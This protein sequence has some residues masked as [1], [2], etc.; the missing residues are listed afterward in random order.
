MFLESVFDKLGGKVPN[1]ILSDCYM[2]AF[3]AGKTA[4]EKH[5]YKL[6]LSRGGLT[7]SLGTEE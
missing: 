3:E 5:G 2:A 7:W 4:V 1:T 6:K